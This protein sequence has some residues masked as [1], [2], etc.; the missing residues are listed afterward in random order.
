MKIASFILVFLALCALVIVNA[1]S[2]RRALATGTSILVVVGGLLL[3]A[4]LFA[5]LVTRP[6]L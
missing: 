1:G 2:G 4:A 3:M 6:A 5:W